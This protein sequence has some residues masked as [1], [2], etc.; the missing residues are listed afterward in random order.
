MALLLFGDWNGSGYS[1][2]LSLCFGA[3]ADAWILP[4]TWGLSALDVVSS[5][6]TRRSTVI[7]PLRIRRQGYLAGSFVCSSSHHLRRNCS[8]DH[9]QNTRIKR[10]LL[11][12]FL[13]RHRKIIVRKKA[14]CCALELRSNKG[15]AAITMIKVI[16]RRRG[17]LLHL[18][19]SHRFSISL[20]IN[21]LTHR[22]EY[23]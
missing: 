17:P 12:I 19:R 22:V 10:Y 15:T 16:W 13:L 1:L 23:S 5:R 2:S 7:E 8:A 4:W 3:E 21:Y 14:W 6:R 11:F 20:A 9:H 18:Q